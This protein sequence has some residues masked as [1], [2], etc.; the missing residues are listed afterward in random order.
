LQQLHQIRARPNIQH[1]LR[2]VNDRALDRLREG[3]GGS[4]AGHRK[5]QKPR[6]QIER[7][8]RQRLRALS[9]RT[10]HLRRQHGRVTYP[11]S[12]PIRLFSLDWGNYS[13]PSEL[14]PRRHH[15]RSS[16]RFLLLVHHRGLICMEKIEQN[17]VKF[18]DI[19]LSPNDPRHTTFIPTPPVTTPPISHSHCATTSLSSTARWLF[20]WF[21][22]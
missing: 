18:P 20:S 13:H 10:R 7:K 17:P 8:S 3:P 12:L 14:P 22:T 5:T 9:V 21:F 2:C 16:R 19:Y 4:P 15:W 6:A 1:V 11:H